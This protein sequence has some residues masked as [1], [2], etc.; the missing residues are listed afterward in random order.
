MPELGCTLP[1]LCRGNDPHYVSDRKKVYNRLSMELT[2]TREQISAITTG[3][4]AVKKSHEDLEMGYNANIDLLRNEVI[5]IAE[6]SRPKEAASQAP[7]SDSLKEK[8]ESLETEHFLCLRQS[9][10]VRTLYVPVLRKRWN[11][12]PKADYA[13]E[14]WLFD[15]QS[16]SFTQWLESQN[17]ADG[18]FCITGRV[19]A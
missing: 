6:Q 4:A 9:Q 5:A 17:T 14:D 11:E 3:L 10:V 12:I 18:W 13:S 8:L 16:T 15:L 2:Q 7:P 1:T 19:S